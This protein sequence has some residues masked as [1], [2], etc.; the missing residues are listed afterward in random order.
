[1]GMG[2]GPAQLEMLDAINAPEFYTTHTGLIED[3]GDGAIRVIRCVKR[4]GV[5]VPVYSSVL[6]ATCCLRSIE[7]ARDFCLKLLRETAGAAH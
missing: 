2:I 1:M 5:L 6:P 7:A 3:A 4:G